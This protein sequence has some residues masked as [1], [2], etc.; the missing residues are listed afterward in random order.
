MDAISRK[1]HKKLANMAK[2]IVDNIHAEV[3]PEVAISLRS[4]R[5]VTFDATRPTLPPPIT[6]T[7]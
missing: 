2:R 1:T 6:S 3:H 7:Q 5:Y 4:L